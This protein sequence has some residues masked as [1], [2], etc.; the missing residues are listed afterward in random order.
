MLWQGVQ[1]CSCHQQRNQPGV[2]PENPSAVLAG[3]FSACE[4]SD[5]LRAKLFALLSYQSDEE[6]VVQAR[7]A[8]LKARHPDPSVELEARGR[9][10]RWV[11]SSCCA[12]LGSLALVIC[13]FKI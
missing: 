11:G 8:K 2:S 7:T 13:F 4:A 6:Q 5:G 9:R 12:R 1:Q 3:P 10:D